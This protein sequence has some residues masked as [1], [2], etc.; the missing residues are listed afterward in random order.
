[1]GEMPEAEAVAVLAD[2]WRDGVSGMEAQ[3]LRMV[4]AEVTR[5]TPK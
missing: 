1:M 5:G 3:A 2:G 4:M